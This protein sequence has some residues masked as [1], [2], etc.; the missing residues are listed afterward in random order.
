METRIPHIIARAPQDHGDG[1]TISD[2]VQI[3]D[4]NLPRN[5]WSIGISDD[6]IVGGD[7]LT[8]TARVRSSQGVTTLP[9]PNF[10][11]SS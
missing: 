2:V 1:V 10:I 7:G 5:L 4:E 3:H 8:R 9:L 11:H 6:I